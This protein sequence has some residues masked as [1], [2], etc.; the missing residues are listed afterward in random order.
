MVEE[1]TPWSFLEALWFDG[2]HLWDP[3]SIFF[4]FYY[5]LNLGSLLVEENI[6]EDI[7]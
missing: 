3:S 7:N 1:T 6:K 5:Y 2:L 4:F